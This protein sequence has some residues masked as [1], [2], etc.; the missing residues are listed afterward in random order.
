M[1]LTENNLEY[2][3]PVS[4]EDLLPQVSRWATFG[5]LALLGT[6]ATSIV[7]SSLI[8][9][10]IIVKAT[11]VVRPEGELRIV[12]A[13]MAGTVTEILVKENQVVAK[14][15]A[16]AKIDTT[17]LQ[18][19][20]NQI[21]Q[22]IRALELEATQ[23]DAQITATQAQITAEKNL[24]QRTIIQ[25]EAELER[26]LREHSDRQKIAQAEVDEAAA[27]L[28]LAAEEAQRYQELENMGVVSKLQISEKL[29]AY[30]AALARQQ[31]T[32]VALNPN[33]AA[34][35]IAKQ[36]IAQEKARGESTIAALNKER[37]NII[38][39]RV[40]LQNQ[41]RSNRQ[42]LTQVLID[43]QK[44]VIRAPEDGIILQLQLR[45]SSQ[46]VRIGQAIAQI[47]PK[48]APLVIKARITSQDIARVKTCKLEKVNNCQNG[49]VSLRISAYPYPDY[50][51]LEGA[52]REI[53]PDTKPSTDTGA[54]N[55]QSTSYYEV[56]IQ[57]K[58]IHLEKNGINY[59]IQAGMEVTADIITKQET[60]ITFVLRKARLLTDI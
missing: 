30:K 4:S 9:Y 33:A 5:G 15:D 13:G 42:Q 57:P 58:N 18:A 60:L 14:G 48:D 44:S 49:R 10:P 28:G 24:T 20:K 25:T 40:R 31:R 39:R 17:N 51:T 41:I 29:Q 38:Q 43:I 23:I 3:K 16:I 19:S 50:G 1:L 26:S 11:A 45:N 7:L 2:L 27:S 46:I 47:A 37:Q 32:I 21:T 59:P 53:T 35:E 56:T 54:K 55:N 52:V 12:E 36:R 8:R 22:N 6:F 34:I